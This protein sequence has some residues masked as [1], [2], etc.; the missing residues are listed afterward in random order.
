MPTTQTPY[1]GKPALLE[2]Y[3]AGKA[4]A[5]A[6][7]PRSSAPRFVDCDKYASRLGAWISGYDDQMRKQSIGEAK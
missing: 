7:A 3:E 1:A 5:I 2:M 4:A 6:K